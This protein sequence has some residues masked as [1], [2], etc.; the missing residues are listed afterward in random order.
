VNESE[1]VK[2]DVVGFAVTYPN[3][4]R[5]SM[6]AQ[7]IKHTSP[8]TLLIA[9]GPHA[10]V[11][12]AEV[13]NY[14]DVVI[15]DEAE[16]TIVE[17]L[18]RFQKGKA[19]DDVDGISYKKEGRVLHNRRRAYRRGAVSDDDLSLLAGFDAASRKSRMTRGEVLCGFANASRGCPFPCTFCY[20]NMIGGTGY[21]SR[22]IASL[23]DDIRRK[24]EFFGTD[25]F[26]F[27]DSNFDTNHKHTREVLRA[28]IDADLQ[29]RFSILSRVDVGA[30]PDILDLMYE[31]GVV[32]LSIGMEAIEDE[33]LASIEKRQTVA[34]IIQTIEEL[35]R[36][37]MTIHGLFMVG[38]DGD[39]EETPW[40]LTEFC[41]QHGV[42]DLN[43][44]CLSEYPELPGRT[45]PRYR[46]CETNADYYTGHFVTTFPRDVKPSVLEL[47]VYQSLMAFYDPRKAGSESRADSQLDIRA[48]QYVQIRRMQR[49]AAEHQDQLRIV[50]APFY[51]MN[52]H[53]REEALRS[54]PLLCHSLSPATLA[55]WKDPSDPT[56]TTLSPQLV[57]LKFAYE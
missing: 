37:Q 19:L 26:W 4:S 3:L 38:F 23:V 11:S 2:S 15:R 12:P 36:R 1:L 27:T 43:I 40:K 8:T 33:R 9:G 57:D 29:C 31:A 7:R 25:R 39:T 45:L 14:V 47:A 13:L 50:E 44:Y 21:R 48:G 5:V 20:E 52:G 35:H 41:R 55:N 34:S 17:V 30:R 56:Q 22:D 46:I 18:D 28:I 42:H 10:T 51:D 6:L 16:D 24:K 53:L 32:E 54:S 49:V